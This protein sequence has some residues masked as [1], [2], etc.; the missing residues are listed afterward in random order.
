MKSHS[1]HAEW[2]VSTEPPGFNSR[3]TL[4]QQHQHG[5]LENPEVPLRE[6]FKCSLQQNLPKYSLFKFICFTNNVLHC[7]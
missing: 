3:V 7:P 5:D 6:V 1:L 2:Q 4:R